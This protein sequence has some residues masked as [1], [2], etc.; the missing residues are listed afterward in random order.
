MYNKDINFIFYIEKMDAN[1][2]LI[3]ASAIII[4]L[5]SIYM[6]VS[7]ARRIE[8]ETAYGKNKQNYHKNVKCGIGN[9]E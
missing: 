7:E 6:T 8:R 3:Q 5:R 4:L 1:L 2:G 9:M